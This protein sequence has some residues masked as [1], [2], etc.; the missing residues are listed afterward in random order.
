[1]PATIVP[2]IAYTQL[3]W[4]RKLTIGATSLG[5]QTTHHFSCNSLTDPDLTDPIYDTSPT[6]F[7]QYMNFYQKYR[8]TASKITV[9]CVPDGPVSTTNTADVGVIPTAGLWSVVDP[10]EVSSQLRGKTIHYAPENEVNKI[11]SYV[12][13]AALF[14]RQNLGATEEFYGTSSTDPINSGRW[15]VTVRAVDQAS[16]LTN[17]YFYITI[18]YYCEFSQ[19]RTLLNSL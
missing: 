9:E 13:T 3:V 7:D 5:A 4:N 8:V 11:E 12:S 6:G 14:G 18:Q 1:M 15:N 2:D 19:R 10:W 17:L 16:N